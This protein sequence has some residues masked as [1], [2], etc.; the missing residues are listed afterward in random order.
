MKNSEIKKYYDLYGYDVIATVLKSKFYFVSFCK[1]S[2][3]GPGSLTLK[4]EKL[5]VLSDAKI[6]KVILHKNLNLT[7]KTNYGF[8]KF[9]N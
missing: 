6:E 4:T 9:S 7:I 8:L 2:I 5:N 3:P 1:N